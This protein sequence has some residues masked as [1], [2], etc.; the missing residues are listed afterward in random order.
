MS[1]QRRATP[2]GPRQTGRCAQPGAMV[3]RVQ[4]LPWS[5]RAN[6]VTVFDRPCG[7]THRGDVSPMLSYAGI[8]TRSTPGQC[9]GSR[10]R[11]SR[12][13]TVARMS[14]P[15][16]CQL[17]ESPVN[18]VPIDDQSLAGDDRPVRRRMCPNP[19]CPSNTGEASL[20][21]RV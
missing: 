8:A 2:L 19:G 16:P 20:A 4:R 3:R 12:G 11:R 9:G 7:L 13:P 18:L 17:C 5:S 21:D 15:E 1:D 10:R 6:G 14:S